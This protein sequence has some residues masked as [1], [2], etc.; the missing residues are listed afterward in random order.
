MSFS[1]SLSVVFSGEGQP[2]RPIAPWAPQVLC[3]PPPGEAQQGEVCSLLLGPPQPADVCNELFITRRPFPVSQLK[4]GAPS[5]LCSSAK[6]SS[7]ACPSWRLAS[8]IPGAPCPSQIAASPGTGRLRSGPL[9]WLR[10]LCLCWLAAAPPRKSATISSAVWSSHRAS[11]ISLC[12]K[13][14]P[15][16]SSQRVK[17]G[18]RRV[19][20][21][22]FPPC[23]VFR[24]L[25]QES[26]AAASS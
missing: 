23:F 10:A 17:G 22:L 5:S 4:C 7:H 21:G 18:T 6:R 8:C 26:R 3:I 2:C 9:A 19:S 14:T 16:A 12:P 20:D 25:L 1:Y 13:K 24:Q 11:S 15:P